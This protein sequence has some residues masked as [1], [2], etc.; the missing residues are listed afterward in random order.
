MD[1]RKRRLGA[2]DNASS[3]SS[4]APRPP[5]KKR[6]TGTGPTNFSTPSSPVKA[7]P[8]QLVIDTNVLDPEK[9]SKYSLLR[10]MKE[11]KAELHEAEERIEELE[12]MSKSLGMSFFTIDVLWKMTQEDLKLMQSTVQSLNDNVTFDSQSVLSE[13]PLGKN[14]LSNNLEQR[15]HDTTSLAKKVVSAVK[16]SLEKADRLKQTMDGEAD[17]TKRKEIAEKSVR[18]EMSELDGLA[19]R[20]AK[21][22][23]D[24]DHQINTLSSQR[25]NMKSVLENALKQVQADEEEAESVNAE[26]QAAEKRRDRSRSAYIA[27][28]ASGGLGGKLES[29]TEGKPADESAQNSTV[30]TPTNQNETSIIR[31]D[32]VEVSNKTI[33]QALMEQIAENQILV[34]YRQKE[35]DT[36][37][38]ER[39]QLRQDIDQLA[40]RVANMSSDRLTDTAYFKNLQC[41]YEYFQ[42][43]S[44][45][46]ENRITQ[47]S[48]ECDTCRADI[49]VL[50]EQ[51]RF[52]HSTSK[53]AMETE[54]RRLEG[55]LARIKKTR[56]HSQ[57][58]LDQIQSREESVMAK[59]NEQVQ[60]LDTR[61][62]DIQAVE[63][64][65]KRLQQ[66]NLETTQGLFEALGIPQAE[67]DAIQEAQAR[68]K[69]AESQ[70]E[71]VRDKLAAYDYA[72]STTM[73]IKSLEDAEYK[74]RHEADALK[75]QI[76]TWSKE[77]TGDHVR[78]DVKEMIQKLVQQN[79][80]IEQLK[81]TVEV[82]EP[83]EA[84][85]LTQIDQDGLAHDKLQ[86][87]NSREVFSFIVH[88]DTIAKL[89]AEIAKYAQTFSRL[90]SQREVEANR[91]HGL[92][93]TNEQQSEHI[94]QLHEREQNLLGQA[95]SKS[96]DLTKKKYEIERI[97]LQIEAGTNNIKE[98]K[99]K[100]SEQEFQANEL[101]KTFNVKDKHLEKATRDKEQIEQELE[102]MKRK[103]E[104]MSQSDNPAEEE[105]RQECEE[106]RTL[107][108]CSACH[109][110]FRSHLLL[111]CM[112]TFCKECIDI[113]I[114]TRQRRCPSCGE[115]FGSSDVRQF[116]F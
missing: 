116:Y 5:L 19:G 35:L 60:L 24:M 97:R 7:E 4:T 113:R 68:I 32:T 40:A 108:K 59:F 57:A 1:D 33:D 36:L 112:H 51:A 11:S 65:I 70:L 76:E 28:L 2:D 43:K 106:L 6:F 114:G 31:P 66:S 54:I 3:V 62:A 29:S 38:N 109:T 45:A 101:Q 99:N 10:S 86:E 44:D 58:L 105:L 16:L 91:M 90:K 93:K 25:G 115:S 50:E 73:D 111:R 55:D 46:L 26:L 104:S 41:S 20:L 98:L 52:N 34:T 30:T 102:R 69:Q 64:D 23:Q 12:S 49:R 42:D 78:S 56:D 77:Y 85:I 22:V 96:Q 61:K 107:L 39:Q 27:S 88:N 21:L 47:L 14:E 9:E 80:T 100:L 17:A 8:M 83:C 95:T 63:A 13:T 94:K 75:H 74:A 79:R 18:A 103:I 82:L 110:R 89:R 92:K 72:K 48:R 87:Q 71:D 81:M 67:A 15:H 84:T 53:T 37:N